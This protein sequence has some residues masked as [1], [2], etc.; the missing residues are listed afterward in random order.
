[1]NEGYEVSTTIQNFAKRME[2]YPLILKTIEPGK[3]V[4]ID[5]EVGAYT[6]ELG[7][8]EKKE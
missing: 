5:L 7:A 8:E 6:K 1:M 4:L 3:K 2:A